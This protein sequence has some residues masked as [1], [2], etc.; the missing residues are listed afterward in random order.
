M[1]IAS[2][3]RKPRPTAWQKR[4]SDS[5]VEVRIDAAVGLRLL[6]E[7]GEHG[8]ALL[9][10]GARAALGTSGS[11]RAATNASSSS[12]PSCVV[13]VGRRCDEVRPDGAQDVGGPALEA[14][15]GE[16]LVELVG[17]AGLDRRAEQLGLAGE[18]AVD[19][20]GGQPGPPGD[21]LHAG[22]S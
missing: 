10:H 12:A 4:T 6:D 5:R 17:G 9:D 14:V 3:S 18:P 19:R 20:A 15:L 16:Q 21:L 11:R 2:N 13:G 22:P 1:P 7:V 8:G